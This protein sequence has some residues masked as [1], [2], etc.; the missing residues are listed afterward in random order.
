[1]RNWSGQKAIG[2]AFAHVAH[3][4]VLEEVVGDEVVAHEPE[5]VGQKDQ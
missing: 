4:D 3:V 2:A 5:K 1:M